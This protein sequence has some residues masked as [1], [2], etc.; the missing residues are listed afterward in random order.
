MPIGN[1]PT[2]GARRF[3]L[4]TMALL[5][6]AGLPYLVG[7][8]H[9]LEHYTGI[10]RGT[11]DFDI[12]VRRADYERITGAL[13]AAGYHTEL[14]FPHWLGKVSSRHGYVD[15]IFNSGNGVTNV[16]EAWFQNASAGQ[17]FG[18]PARMCPVEEMIW[19]KAFVMERERYDC[20]DIM[21]LLLTCATRLDWPRL[22]ERFAEHWRVLFS[23]LCLFGFVYPGER[24]RIPEWVM[25]RFVGLLEREARARPPAQHMCQGTLLSR[26]QYLVDVQEWGFADVRNTKASMMTARDIV[27]WTDAIN[28]AK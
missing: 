9:A 13:A 15:V 10:E 27:L 8:G 18:L 17:V 25:S 2:P 21:H 19:S 6:E 4:H 14:T 11:K 7:G 1:D 3:Y 5:D 12:F 24:A 28:G 16:D 23:Y 20:A 26:E 22:V